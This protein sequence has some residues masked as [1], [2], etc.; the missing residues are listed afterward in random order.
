MIF[1]NTKFQV[2]LFSEMVSLIGD[3]ILAVAL[4]I[5]VYDITGSA[6]TVSI[7]M[8]LKAIPSLFLGS[9]A[10]AMV[11]RLNRKWVMV[12]SNLTQGALVLII[13]FTNELLVIYGVYFLLS[14]V[15]QFFIP[16][17]AATL[18]S[19][20]PEKS[21]MAANSLFSMAFVGAI[22]LGP[23]IAGILIEAYGTSAAF[24]A[25][26]FT[27]LVP[28]VAVAFLAL[29]QKSN[30]PQQSRF[31]DELRAGFSYIS[32]NPTIRAALFLSGLVYM[33]I[34]AVS[35]LGIVI[36]DKVLG[37]GAGGY[38]MMMSSMGVGMLVGAIAAGKWGRQFDKI[39]LAS[40]GA[41]MAGAAIAI[42][43]FATSLYFA[44]ALNLVLG[45]GMV[46][47]QTSA[48]TLFQTS[49]EELRGRVMGVA[50]SLMGAASF[51]AMGFAGFV[52]EWIG[53]APV[54]ALV[55]GASVVAGGFFFAAGLSGRQA[56]REK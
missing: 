54:L 30:P 50:Q 7:L 18:P 27:F 37:V 31:V 8:M 40:A 21:L 15:N 17:R 32:Q 28:A 39:Q 29:P 22:A 33:G 11:D 20:V 16:A 13:P 9:V 51:L 4:V 10:G 47:V 25:D 35:V 2:L 6:A 44:F 55:G 48:N 24:F 46:F 49:P 3:R 14:V 43:P 56:T 23:M 19:I 42:L 5:L 53:F 41:T 1:K 45:A 38:G 36:A 34:G 26:S 12:F 52:A